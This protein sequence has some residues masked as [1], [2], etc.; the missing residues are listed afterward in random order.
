MKPRMMPGQEPYTEKE[1][2]ALYKLISEAAEAD[3]TEEN[4]AE[5]LAG[6]NNE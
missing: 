5:V 2:A 6:E 1:L 4:E 3:I